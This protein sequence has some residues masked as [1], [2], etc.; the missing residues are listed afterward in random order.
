M[1]RTPEG[2]FTFLFYTDVHIQPERRAPEGFAQAVDAMRAAA[3]DAA[4]AVC[5]GDL[6][7]DANSVPIE[8]ASRLFD[9]YLEQ[10][11][12]LNMPIYHTFGNHDFFGLNA[13]KSGANPGDPHWGRQLF[14]EKLGQTQTYYSFNH[15]GWH[16]AVLDTNDFPANRSWRGDMD[17]AQRDW[18]RDDLQRAEGAPT[19]L[20]AH[21]PLLTVFGQVSDQATDAPESLMVIGNSKEVTDLIRP[22]NV[23]A[24]L[25]GHTHI[26]EEIDYLGTR[27]L[28]AGSL[29]GDW[30][31]GPRLGLHPEG[32]AVCT[33]GPDGAFG[34][35]YVPYGWEAQGAP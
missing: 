31:K 21:I 11:G 5:G 33:C 25:Q 9:L 23:K 4:F 15:S 19:V 6:V 22:F 1:R 27:Y 12:R 29:C 34:Y 32:F 3:A 20:M 2:G 35:R 18:L 16:F 7:L 17:E 13:A 26:V 24:V 28:S 8:R 14:L 30:W 10:A